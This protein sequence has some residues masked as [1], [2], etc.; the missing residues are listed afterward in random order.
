MR[1]VGF[2]IGVGVGRHA[3][4]LEPLSGVR[5]EFDRGTTPKCSTS[6]GGIA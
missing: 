5:T 3:D 6:S 2:D 1:C 4:W